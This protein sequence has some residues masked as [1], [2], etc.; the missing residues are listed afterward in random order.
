MERKPNIVVF[1]TDQHR[2]DALGCNN[3]PI[4]KTPNI[5][6]IAREGIN[7]R[8]AYANQ[9]LCLPSRS[10]MITGLYP[11]VHRSTINGIPLDNKLPV[12]PELLRHNGYQTFASG[13]MHLSPISRSFNIPPDEP[14]EV[15][16]KLPYYGFE[17][18]AFVEGYKSQYLKMIKSKYPKLY[19]NACHRHPFEPNGIFQTYAPNPI[20]EDIHRTTWIAENAIKFIEQRNKK[21]PFLLH[22]SFWD[23]HH[24]F[25]P[26]APFHK[27]YNPDDMKLP[28]PMV[29]N[30]KSLANCLL[31]WHKKDHGK[32]GKAFKEYTID[33]WKQMKAYYYGMI[34]LIDK[35]VGK[36]MDYLKENALI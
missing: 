18:V 20:T 33:D 19:K 28:I 7:F 36:V 12:Y 30:K 16:N 26:P 24:P 29:K 4:I 27:M 5:D 23:P 10:S 21:K 3:N 35:N 22:C 13:K 11:S 14:G 9:P 15:P 8:N 25:D 34:S 6:A 31:K 1:I 2:Q 17:K 32:D